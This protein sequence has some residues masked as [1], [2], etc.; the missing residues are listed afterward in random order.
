MDS[1]NKLQEKESQK[2]KERDGLLHPQTV[3]IV[4]LQNCDVNLYSPF[5]STEADRYTNIIYFDHIYNAILWF[6]FVYKWK[7]SAFYLI[8][9]NWKKAIN[10]SE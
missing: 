4:T 2:R 6:S 9:F 7:T 3:T 5:Q 8:F 10:I 1:Q